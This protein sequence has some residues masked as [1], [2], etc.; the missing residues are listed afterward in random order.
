MKKICGIY[1]IVN[2]IN[3]KQY[4]G[5]SIDI[6][7]RWIRHRYELNTNQHSNPI[8]QKAWN[9]YGAESFIFKI[10][11]KCNKNQL[12]KNEK[13]EVEKISHTHRYNILKDY[14]SLSGKNN[15]FYGKKHSKETKKKLSIIGK[16]KI[17]KKNPNYGNK[18]SIQTKIKNGHNKKTKLTIKQVKKI[19]TIKN[20][21][22]QEIA[23]MYNI[24]RTV[25]TRI[26]NGKRWGLITNIKGE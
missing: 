2:T 4:I 16:T 17:G 19:I 21:T 24:S 12:N 6:H 7:N 3:N 8:L 10:V 25:I 9:K 26:K 22:H 5:Q 15:P 23:D 20:K 14:Y 11:I 18:Y 13:I 1:S